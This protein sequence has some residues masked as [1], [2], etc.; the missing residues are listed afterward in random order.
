MKVCFFLVGLSLWRYLYLDW[1]ILSLSQELRRFFD[2]ADHKLFQEKHKY[3]QLTHF[4]SFAQNFLCP[5]Q[6][7]V[8]SSLFVGDDSRFFTNC[9]KKSHC[10]KWNRQDPVKRPNHF[11][12]ENTIYL[13][14]WHAANHL[15]THFNLIKRNICVW[16]L[17]AVYRKCCMELWSRGENV[18]FSTYETIIKWCAT[19]IKKEGTSIAFGVHTITWSK[20][21]GLMDSV[22][23]N[24]NR[25]CPLYEWH[26]LGSFNHSIG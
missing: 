5:P 12:L 23:V 15:V 20:Y 25:S 4:F 14:K 11:T 19:M 8:I 26:C 9:A 3:T 1:I 2:H 13:R 22:G 17:C 16:S 7:C 10:E 21:R 18:D 24:G 6:F